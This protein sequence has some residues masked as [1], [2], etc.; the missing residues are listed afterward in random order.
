MAHRH[1]AQPWSSPRQTLFGKMAP[2]VLARHPGEE[3]A[4]TAYTRILQGMAEI[5]AAPVVHR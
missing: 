5:N 4:G 3:L 1:R 2:H